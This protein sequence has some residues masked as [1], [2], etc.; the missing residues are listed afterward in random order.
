MSTTARANATV[1]SVIL[2]AAHAH[3]FWCNRDLCLVDCDGGTVV[4]QT[5]VATVCDTQI[6]I[7]RIDDR[8]AN[9]TPRT[10]QPRARNLGKGDDGMTFAQLGELRDAIDLAQ[11]I[12]G[13]VSR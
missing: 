12:L 3:P 11:M 1:Q 2:P 8:D 10:G 9:N 5:V 6:I 4:H 13:E 7:E